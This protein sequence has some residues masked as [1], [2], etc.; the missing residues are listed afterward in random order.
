M[1]DINDFNGNYNIT[2]KIINIIHKYITN[3]KTVTIVTN[4]LLL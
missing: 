1:D 4:L 2:V 3:N